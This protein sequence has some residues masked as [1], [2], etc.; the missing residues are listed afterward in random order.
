MRLVRIFACALLLSGAIVGATAADTLFF[1]GHGGLNEG[2]TQ[3]QALYAANGCGG[4]FDFNSD[5]SLPALGNYHLLFISVPGLTAPGAFF[6][7]GEKASI[8]AWLANANNRIV[9]IG[10]WDG[11][12]GAGAAVLIDLINSI[13]VGGMAFLPGVYDSGCYAYSCA[14]ILGIDPLTAGL[15]H[16]CKAATSTWNQGAGSAVAFPYENPN[17]PW[18]ITN[19]TNLPCIVGIGDSNALSDGCGYLTSD[20]NTQTFALRLCSVTCSGDPVD[21]RRSTWGRLKLMYQ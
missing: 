4:Q 3:L 21:V 7:A 18:V 5:A 15:S 19:G 8:T 14:G 11:F 6:T 20:A 13:G 9:L 12:Y 2:H 17:S 16:L 10:E 1:F